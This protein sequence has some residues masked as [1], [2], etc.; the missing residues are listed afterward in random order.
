MAPPA[1]GVLGDRDD[2]AVG[3]K[4]S[5]PGRV[6]GDAYRHER[7]VSFF[8]PAQQPRRLSLRRA[9][10]SELDDKPFAAA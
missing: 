7:R 6:G 4:H 2:A 10:Y 5:T 8:G 9:R 1:L 3:Q